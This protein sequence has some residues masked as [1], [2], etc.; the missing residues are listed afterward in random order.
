MGGVIYTDCQLAGLWQCHGVGRCL[1][2]H[3]VPIR[4]LSHLL[5]IDRSASGVVCDVAVS[6]AQPAGYVM[7]WLLGPT[8]G[9]ASAAVL[10][11]MFEFR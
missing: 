7:L 3:H 11:R 9:A 10:S 4:Y 8:A 2:G 1:V 6:G 5:G